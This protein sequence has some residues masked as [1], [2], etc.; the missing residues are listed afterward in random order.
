MTKES[1]NPDQAEAPEERRRSVDEAISEALRVYA[2]VPQF[3]RLREDVLIDDVWRQP[4]LTPHDRSIV[5]CTILAVTGKLDDLGAHLRKAA[6]NGVTAD[7]LRGMTVQ[8]AFYAG[9][10]AGLGFA[11]MALPYLEQEAK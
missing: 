7:E 4:E 10:P 1:A 2:V 8:I 9:W 5:T 6:E 11:R 3:S